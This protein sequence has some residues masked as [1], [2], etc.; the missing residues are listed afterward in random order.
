MK[1]INLLISAFC[2]IIL[3]SCGPKPWPEDSF[4][5]LKQSGVLSIECQM[6]Y[7][8]TNTQEDVYLNCVLDVY[9]QNFPNYAD[10]EKVAT[11]N[12]QQIKEL[13]ISCI[14]QYSGNDINSV[15]NII[16][17]NDGVRNLKLQL[18]VEYFEKYKVLMM[19][20]VR[21]EF[22]SMENLV[23]KMATDENYIPNFINNA[24][25]ECGAIIMKEIQI[26]QEKKLQEERKTSEL[27]NLLDDNLNMF[28]IG[29]LSIWNK[30]SKSIIVAVGYY[31]Y[32]EKWQGWVSDGWW[33]IASGEKATINMPLN[34][35]GYMNGI[36]YYCAKFKDGFGW[37]WSGENSFIVM[38][39]N[40]KIPNADKFETLS[41]NS[42][43]RYSTTFK[44]V[45][46]G[47][48]KE[49]TLNLTE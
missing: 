41:C 21:N 20:K 26:E 38:D 16:E 9:K 47:R 37:G 4:N 10:F 12:P 28:N 40:F 1:R 24:D 13:R 14:K 22:Q 45:E 34:E 43:F 46:I 31:Y 2:L 18:P 44:K 8:L 19:S 35:N 33:N 25:K 39:E 17:N 23:N 29:S 5:Q 27:Y 49:Y 6:V 36:I 11:E 32:G 15:W 3:T 48:T 30:T 42:R 7:L